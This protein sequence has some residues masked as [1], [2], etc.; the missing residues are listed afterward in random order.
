MVVFLLTLVAGNP[1]NKT[2]TPYGFI[3]GTLPRYNLSGNM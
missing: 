3:T 1:I 2:Y